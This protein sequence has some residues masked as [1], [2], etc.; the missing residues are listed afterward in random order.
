VEDLK[1]II[2]GI[3]AAE[4]IEIADAQTGQKIRI[5]IT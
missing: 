5:P 4:E 2:G 1:K 3:T